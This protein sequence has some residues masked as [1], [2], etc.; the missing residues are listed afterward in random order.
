VAEI[1]CSDRT[2]NLIKKT[3]LF[4]TVI[5]ALKRMFARVTTRAKSVKGEQQKLL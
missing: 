5:M 3:A 2:I 1:E 4:G